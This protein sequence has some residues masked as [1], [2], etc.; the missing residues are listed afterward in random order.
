[1]FKTSIQTTYHVCVPANKQYCG[2]IILLSSHKLAKAAVC[3]CVSIYCVV[4]LCV[5]IGDW[6]ASHN[7]ICCTVI[8]DTFEKSFLYFLLV[9]DVLLTESFFIFLGHCKTLV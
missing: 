7:F 1:M 6:V 5:Y 2:C 9:L 3:W 8:P 4:R